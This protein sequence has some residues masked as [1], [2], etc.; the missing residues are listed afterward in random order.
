MLAQEINNPAYSQ[1]RDGMAFLNSSVQMSGQYLVQQH[2][3]SFDILANLSSINHHKI[4]HYV[5]WAADIIVK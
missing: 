3:R 5:I 1:L 2:N 4:Q